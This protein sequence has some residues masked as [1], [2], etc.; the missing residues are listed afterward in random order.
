MYGIT[1]AFESSLGSTPDPK[2]W[3]AEHCSNP[4]LEE[5]VTGLVGEVAVYNKGLKSIHINLKV[6]NEHLLS[7]CLSA[8]APVYEASV[9]RSFKKLRGI[10][11]MKFSGHIWGLEYAERVRERMMLR[12][13]E[14]ITDTTQDAGI[15]RTVSSSTETPSSATEQSRSA[16]GVLGPQSTG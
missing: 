10:Q 3:Y 9:L 13:S 15:A 2:V 12:S 5:V 6:R 8:P 14:A 7:S 4:L 16:N 1:S 11:G